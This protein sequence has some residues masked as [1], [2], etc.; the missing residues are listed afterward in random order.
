MSFD[1]DGMGTFYK[2]SGRSMRRTEEN[3]PV[4]FGIMKD[5]YLASLQSDSSE[6]II[7]A[8]VSFKGGV[9]K[10][11]ISNALGSYLEGDA[12]V[13][14]LDYVQRAEESNACDTVDYI[15][16]NE[17]MS[18]GE[19]IDELSKRYKF[20]I[21]DTPGD[22]SSP[23]VT[24][25][26]HRVDRFII[27]LTTGK[28]ARQATESSLDVLFGPDAMLKGK[29]RVFFLLNMYKLNSKRDQAVKHFTSLLH[30]MEFS[31]EIEIT[32]KLVGLKYSEA[33][34]RMEEEAQSVGTLAASNKGAYGPARKTLDS[35]CMKIEEF[36]EL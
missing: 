35:V 31:E 30:N 28:R 12:V 22:I 17:E 4:K 8:A 18:V 7:M 29:I 15:D 33:I 6:T 3:H 2:K 27:P 5:E 14:N 11:T 26:L 23:T 1:Y 9:G 24:E 36:F 20:I 13:L 21:L 19:L 34:D 10:S 32:P 25:I 16:Y